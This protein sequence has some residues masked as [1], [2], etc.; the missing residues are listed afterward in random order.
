[1]LPRLNKTRCRCSLV[2]LSCREIV[3]GMMALLSMI[4]CDSDE[5][6]SRYQVPKEETLL[7]EN[8]AERENAADAAATETRP[9]RMLVAMLPR[10]MTT[11]F[12]K[13]V[14]PV[15]DIK[16]L[17]P[18]F[19]KF[20]DT[21]QFEN[22]EPTWQLPANWTESL[23]TVSFR[24]KTINIPATDDHKPL[25][26]TVSKLNSESGDKPEFVLPNLNRWRG[27]LNLPAVTMA[28]LDRHYEKSEEHGITRLIFDLT[29]QQSSRPRPPFASG[30]GVN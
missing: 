13:L 24:Y 8:R 28:E 2:R 1:M 4:G 20:I 26:I 21:V 25:E 27:Q 11:W 7:A 29:G 30:R 12:I 5:Q 22:E 14:G 10:Q 9:A 3:L 19:L 6:I 17:K 16:E 23:S 18:T 15:D